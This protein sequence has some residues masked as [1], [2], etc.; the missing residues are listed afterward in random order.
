MLYLLVIVRHGGQPL[1]GSVF[2]MIMRENLSS[3]RLLLRKLWE[4][5]LRHMLYEYINILASSNESYTC[6]AIFK[7]NVL[8]CSSQGNLCLQIFY[9]YL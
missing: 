3:L 5:R 8:S 4:N 1:E 6:V 9:G 7:K 2:L